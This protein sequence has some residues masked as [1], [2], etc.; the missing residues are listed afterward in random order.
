MVSILL[1]VYMILI[2]NKNKTLNYY[3]YGT[4]LG[5]AHHVAMDVGN[6]VVAEMNRL[7]ETGEAVLM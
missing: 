7:R 5:V 1:M 4:P 6:V 3:C 2:K